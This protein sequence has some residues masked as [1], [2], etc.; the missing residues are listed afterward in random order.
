MCST[1]MYFE[2]VHYY[3]EVQYVIYDCSEIVS[4]RDCLNFKQEEEELG[5]SRNNKIVNDSYLFGAQFVGEI[6]RN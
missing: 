6:T 5:G 2:E 3:F 1:E 4:E